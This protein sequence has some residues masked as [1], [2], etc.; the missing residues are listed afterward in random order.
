MVISRRILSRGIAKEKT[1][2]IVLSK[3]KKNA[4]SGGNGRDA[5]MVCSR[6]V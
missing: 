5:K 1:H 4:I 2:R 3:I 6:G